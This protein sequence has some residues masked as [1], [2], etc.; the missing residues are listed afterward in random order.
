MDSQWLQSNQ[1]IKQNK[2]QIPKVFQS[3]KN[4][5]VFSFSGSLVCPKR[6]QCQ[7]SNVKRPEGIYFP[8][9]QKNRKSTNCDYNPN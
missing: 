5:Y 2:E 1:N 9:A 4:A 6:I 8:D 3:Y 7:E